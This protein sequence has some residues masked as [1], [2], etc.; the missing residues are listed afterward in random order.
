M[1]FLKRLFGFGS[2]SPRAE[3]EVVSWMV[4]SNTPVDLDADSLRAALDAIYPG[5]FL[6]ANDHSYVIHGVIPD[7]QFLI[8]S[9]VAGAEG[10]FF[11]NTMPC[12]YADFS[13]FAR[14]I[15]DP[16]F[17]ALAESQQAW[18]SID[19]MHIHTTEANAY[20]FIG[21]ALTK[22]APA[23]AAVL[24][25]PPKQIAI[26][27]DDETRRRLANGLEPNGLARGPD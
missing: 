15:E 3:R 2:A 10:M 11:L 23:D 25:H 27:L 9:N 17:R 13:D 24:V 1:D 22:L 16:D 21:A 6:P 4:L 19:A 5:E 8:Q 18:L 12:P 20:R 26:R 7:A 14:S